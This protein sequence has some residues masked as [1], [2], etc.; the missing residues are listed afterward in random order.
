[1]TKL[2]QSRFVPDGCER[3][4]SAVEPEIRAAVAAEYSERLE[5]AG[6]W[7][8]IRLRREIEREVKLR[9]SKVAPYDAQY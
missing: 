5:R 8:R 4:R 2:S 3:A 1:M 7:A 9:V 6:L